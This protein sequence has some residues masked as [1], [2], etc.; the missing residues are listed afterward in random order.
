[1]YIMNGK[2]YTKNQ[3]K[4]YFNNNAKGNAYNFASWLLNMRCM[5]LIVKGV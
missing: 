3:L 2:P 4:R 5:G 1:M